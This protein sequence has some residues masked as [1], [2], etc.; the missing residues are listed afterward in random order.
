MSHPRIIHKPPTAGG[1]AETRIHALFFLA[2]LGDWS[3]H[4]PS[5]GAV[6]VQA[7]SP[8]L[9]ELVGTELRT[10]V[11]ARPHQVLCPSLPSGHVGGIRQKHTRTG[12]TKLGCKEPDNKYF[13][14]CHTVPMETP[15][16]GPLQRGS[17][18]RGVYADTTAVSQGD[19]VYETW[20]GGSGPQAAD[21]CSRSWSLEGKPWSLSSVWSSR[22][23]QL[24]RS[25]LCH[26]AGHS[27][28]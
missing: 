3:R 19:S 15:P 20:W 7:G 13:S 25:L 27:L 24:T 2:V 6:R 17:S 4:P 11:H 9:P 10:H 22:Q 26:S 1:P 14:L 16:A 28:V 8:H 18:R 23:S 5:R 21:C 12:V